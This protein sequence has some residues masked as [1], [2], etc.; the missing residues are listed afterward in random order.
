ML[1]ISLVL[2]QSTFSIS[3][4]PNI[5]LLY[6]RRCRQLGSCALNPM[7]KKKIDYYMNFFLTFA[8]FLKLLIVIHNTVLS[9]PYILE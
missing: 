6:S 7:Y 5:T 1:R 9:S 3:S 2:Y 4:N 8:A